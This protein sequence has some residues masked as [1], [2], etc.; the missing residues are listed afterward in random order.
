MANVQTQNRSS[1]ETRARPEDRREGEREVRAPVAKRRTAWD[2]S[3]GRRSA[4]SSPFSVM[5]RFLEDVDDA[6]DRA[7]FSPLVADLNRARSSFLPQSSWAP[8][9]EVQTEEDR[10]VVRA[11]LPGVRQED[12]RVETEPD[13]LTIAGE[14][15]EERKETKEGVFHSERRYG[16]FKRCLRLPRGADAEHAEARFDN[17][18]LEVRIPALKQ[19]SRRVEVRT[20]GGDDGPWSKRDA[21]GDSSHA[22]RPRN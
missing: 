13:L 11:D 18:V 17:G 7:L 4:V 3:P 19:P 20:G 2:A 16:Q 12:I 5:H 9:V 10:I 8:H 22:S 1:D 21:G 6:F 14:R 15:H